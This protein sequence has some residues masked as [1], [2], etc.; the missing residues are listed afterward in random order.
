MDFAFS[1]IFK[2]KLN[3]RKVE[4]NGWKL[5]K[6]YA[7]DKRNGKCSSKIIK[8]HELSSYLVDKSFELNTIFSK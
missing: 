3:T 5:Q 6:P 7:E 8:L 2:L 1:R 4:W